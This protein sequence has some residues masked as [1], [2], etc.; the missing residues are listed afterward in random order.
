M[1]LHYIQAGSRVGKIRATY[2]PAEMTGARTPGKPRRSPE[3]KG[4]LLL[5]LAVQYSQAQGIQLDKAFCIFLVVGTGIIFKGG[6]GLVEQVI[7][8]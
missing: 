3:I 1:N 5:F 7:R 4:G 8:G 2:C 6:D